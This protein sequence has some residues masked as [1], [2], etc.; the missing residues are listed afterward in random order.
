MTFEI[1]IETKKK[2]IIYITTIIYAITIITIHLYNRY[3]K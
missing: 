3:T 2:I 1:S